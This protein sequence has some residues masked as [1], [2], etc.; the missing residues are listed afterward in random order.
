MHKTR[1]TQ[2]PFLT[3]AVL[4]LFDYQKAAV[5]WL[6]TW[7]VV[8]TLPSLT[9]LTLKIYSSLL[10]SCAHTFSPSLCQSWG[11]LRHKD[12]AG[13]PVCLCELHKKGRLWPSHPV[14]WR[15]CM[16]TYWRPIWVGLM[17][18][19]EAGNEIFAVLRDDIPHHSTQLSNLGEI[20]GCGLHWT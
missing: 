3:H 14:F 8:C 20:T 4:L 13:T 11:S 17:L 1:W 15:T 7:R 5:C 16:F 19:G 18:Q 2:T 9:Q 6:Q 12:A 10:G